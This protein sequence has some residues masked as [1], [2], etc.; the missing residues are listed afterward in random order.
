MGYAFM[1]ESN[2]KT[3]IF[4]T[5]QQNGALPFALIKCT[6]QRKLYPRTTA[7]APVFRGGV[8]ALEQVA[9]KAQGGL[10]FLI[11][12]LAGFFLG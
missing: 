10:N 8:Y 7:D 6:A 1:Y 2:Q 3:W 4:G 11:I 5:N 9:I 12:F